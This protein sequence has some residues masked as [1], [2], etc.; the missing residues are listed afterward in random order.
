MT[1]TTAIPASPTAKI[2]QS[3]AASNG[4]PARVPTRAANAATVQTKGIMRARSLRVHARAERLRP[5]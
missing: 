2:A 5:E 3:A 4:S 1:K